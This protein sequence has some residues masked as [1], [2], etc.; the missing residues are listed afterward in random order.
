MTQTTALEATLTLRRFADRSQLQ[1]AI[2]ERLQQ[3][4]TGAS[5]EQPAVMLS[6]GSTPIPA[7]LA[8]A[9]RNLVPA[10]GLT[11]LFSDDRYVPSDSDQS[12]YHQSRPLF[13]AL[14]L[15]PEQVL[16]IRTELPLPQATA[17]SA[18][19][20]EQL[21]TGDRRIT[22]GLLGIGADGHTCSL[23]SA[24]DLQRAR[25]HL[26]IS[27]HRPD[28]RDAVSVTPAVLE[29]VEQLIFMVTGADKQTALDGL[30]HRKADLTAWAAVRGC[31][32]VE[33]WAD[34]SALR[35]QEPR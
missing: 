32:S 29:R 11:V 21:L 5:G 10:P 25:G 6:G 27:V 18:R 7:Y 12:N 35:H 15:G 4:L 30:L 34:A 20:L 9:A 22:L 19:Q 16:R 33:V 24:A 8:L 1:V 28:G 3:V 17:A 2:E 26:A 13:T 14:R 23:F 31:R